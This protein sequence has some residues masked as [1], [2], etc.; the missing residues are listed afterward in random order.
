MEPEDQI[1]KEE[2]YSSWALL[3]QTV[4]LIG[5]L[6][7]SYYLHL[8]Q[9][10]VIHETI[11]SIFA[12]MI[13][14]LIIRLSPASTIQ[15]MVT[16]NYTY[17]FN[18]LLPPIILNS[19]YEMQRELF[20]RKIGTSLLFA[21]MGTFISALVIGVLVGILAFFGI[22]SL[23]LSFIDSLIFGSILSAT[24]TVTVLA[25]FQSL[26]VDPKLYTIIFGESL[27]NDAV[28]IVLNSNLYML[29]HSQ[30]RKYSS[31]ESCIIALMAYSSYLLSNGIDS[32]G[33]VSLL[34]CGIILKHYAYDNMS[35]KTKRTTKYL[36]H[37]LAQLSE[38]FIFIYLGLTL[39]TK[40]DLEYKPIFIFFTAIFIC[41]GRYFAIFPLS[42]LVNSFA[43]Y[44]NEID[45]IP[46]E[47]SI[48]LFWAGLRGA[49]A[50]ALTAELEG[51]NANAMLTTIL[52]VVV[53]SVIIFG[54]STSMMLEVLK[55]QTEM[56]VCDSI[57][58]AQLNNITSNETERKHWFISF[59]DR[60]LKPLFTRQKNQ[61]YVSPHDQNNVESFGLVS[62]NKKD[63]ENIEVKNNHIRN[64]SDTF[65]SV[66]IN[67]FS[68]TNLNSNNQNSE[69]NLLNSSTETSQ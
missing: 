59:D 21:F 33:V 11:V 67:N 15:R 55:I 28:S 14:G 20:F 31:I 17:F 8:K 47:H 6:W 10:R 46:Q 60:F 13:V 48:M 32:S 30:L 23:S 26:K 56:I 5:A 62:I 69:N 42:F 25:I 39:F 3:I 19:G 64:S 68:T 12:G 4:L 35:L 22:D 63:N 2:L 1:E 53:L 38:N 65:A 9:I 57:N 16:F 49:V 58:S 7:T 18:I 52:V 50:F 61:K 29:K 37:V 34:F 40:S 45:S 43:R 44:R 54:G 36:F 41:I 24:D 27:L 51:R 66:T